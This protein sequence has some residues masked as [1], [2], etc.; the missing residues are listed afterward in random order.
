MIPECLT[1]LFT[2]TSGSL[3]H[4]TS[5]AVLVGIKLRRSAVAAHRLLDEVDRAL[6]RLVQTS[7]TCEGT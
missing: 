4:C 2:Q 3:G 7:E 1:V 5:G 6:C